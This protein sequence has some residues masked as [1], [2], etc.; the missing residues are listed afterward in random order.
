VRRHEAVI[1]VLSSGMRAH[2]P[3]PLPRFARHAGSQAVIPAPAAKVFD[4]LD[5]HA[6][7]AGHMNRSGWRMA[8][9]SLE[10]LLDT[11]RGRRV[12][13]HIVLRGSVLGIRLFVDAVVTER[14]P[15]VHKAWEVVGEP[16]LLVIGRYCMGF[17]VTPDALPGRS[18]LHVWI[19]YD[20]PRGV[21]RFGGRLLG[22]RY[23][24]WCAQEMVEEARRAFAEGAKRLQS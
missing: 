15:P 7:T 4:F 16:R 12:G 14:V 23:A 5:N 11:E 17:T 1:D 20:L 22:S 6:R 24:E 18:H 8:W 21:W 10:T 19:D 2:T 3:R 9:G 13:S